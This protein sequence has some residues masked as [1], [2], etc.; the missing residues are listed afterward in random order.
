[1]YLPFIFIWRLAHARGEMTSQDDVLSTSTRG[2]L[3]ANPL[4]K[5]ENLQWMLDVSVSDEEACR[6]KRTRRLGGT[7]TDG[8]FQLGD[9]RWGEVSSDKEME[10]EME[11]Q[12]EGQTTRPSARGFEETGQSDT[13]G[14]CKEDGARLP[15]SKSKA[16]AIEAGFVPE[17]TD[18]LA[19]FT[20]HLSQFMRFPSTSG[21]D[22]A[23][24]SFS[25]SL[26]QY[27][28][29]PLSSYATLFTS[30]HRSPL[31]AHFVIH[32]HDH[33]VAGPHYDLRLQI[34]PTSSASW[35]LPYG[36][37]GGSRRACPPRLAVETR[38]HCLWNHLVE[39]A[40]RKTGS[41]IVWDTGTYEIL[42]YESA[43]RRQQQQSDSESEDA[44]QDDTTAAAAAA[45]SIPTREET[46]NGRIDV[47]TQQQKMHA[48]FSARKMCLR[49]NGAR[50]PRPYVVKMWLT[51]EEELR[52]KE[53]EQGRGRQTEKEVKRKRR[54]H[55]E[56]ETSS[57]S[58]SGP[59]TS[60]VS[61]DNDAQ[62]R[63]D[64][65]RGEAAQTRKRHHHTTAAAAET[66]TRCGNTYPGAENT[67]G[68]V[69][70]RRWFVALDH[71][72][73]QDGD[74]EGD[75]DCGRLKYPFEVRGPMHERSVLTG[76]LG[77]DV[78]SDEGVVG[79]VGRKGWRSR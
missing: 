47:Q 48:A 23:S 30:N 66:R 19:Y 35:A 69:H 75:G 8:E 50:L 18:H 15:A 46:N 59:S 41:L 51:R 21:L 31:G 29:I 64:S 78:L 67:V 11:V 60:G 72:A 58:S 34:N 44:S 12:V 28:R 76:R 7:G 74:G 52:G 37:P 22:P 77:G 4:V 62:Q 63:V 39:T 49:L 38:V 36:P 14:G 10:K 55:T 65:S 40:S 1:M 53:R 79:F 68:S 71:R 32:Q 17:M 70:Q 57:S 5:K 24:F 27:S 56:R 43:G 73:R 16:A 26:S 6:E 45:D 61:E 33:P 54:R 13:R 25:S 9:G 3:V 2:V 20:A 42:P